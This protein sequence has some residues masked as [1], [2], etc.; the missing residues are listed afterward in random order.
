MAVHPIGE[1]YGTTE[2]R[3]VGNEKY[4]FACV[5]PKSMPPFLIGSVARSKRREGRY[6]LPKR[7]RRK[8][9]P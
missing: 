7:S 4:R 2:M 9:Y 6:C 8:N 1:R 5:Q 3:A